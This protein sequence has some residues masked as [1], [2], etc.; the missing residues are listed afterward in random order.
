MM[1]DQPGD[2]LGL[3]RVQPEARAKLQRDLGAEH[4]MVAAAA[5]GD[6]VQQHRDIKRPARRDLAEQGGRQRM[7]VGQLAAL[8]RAPAGRSPG[9]NAR[10][11]YNGGTCR[12]ASARRPGRSR[13][14]S[15]RTRRPRSSTAAPRR[16]LSRAVSTSRNK[17]LARG[18]SR[19]RS[20]SR[21]SRVAARIALGWISSPSRAAS[22]N[23]STSRTGSVANQ[24]SLGI[25]RR[26]R[27]SV[28]PS[29]RLGRRRKRRQREAAALARPSARRAGRGTGRSGRRPPWRSGNRIA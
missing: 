29:S 4:A 5:L 19:T 3:G 26:P 1:A 15:G 25:E 14:R 17:A 9:S 23:S 12:T 24:S 10:R 2:G 8:D 13:E 11:P 28:K 18:S 27:S 7:V 20:T 22:A 16:A 21:A 6:V